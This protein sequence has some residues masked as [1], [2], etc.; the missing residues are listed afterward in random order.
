MKHINILVCPVGTDGCSGYRIKNPYKAIDKL[1]QDGIDV[2]FLTGKTKGEDI[3][4]L[5]E[6]ADIIIFRAGHDKLFNMIIDKKI[7]NAKLVIDFDF[8]YREHKSIATN[9][10][11]TSIGCRDYQT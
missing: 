6:G 10:S 2:I 3:L 7:G 8:L 5:V 1:N 9:K 11:I 4:S